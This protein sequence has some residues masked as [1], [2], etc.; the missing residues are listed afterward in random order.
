MEDMGSFL[1]VDEAC[2]AVSGPRSFLK[3]LRTILSA[4]VAL[5]KALVKSPFEKRLVSLRDGAFINT[6]VLNEH[7]TEKPVLVL[8]HGWGSGLGF[9]AKNLDALAGAYRIYCFDWI[10]SGGSSR[11]KFDTSMNV[12]ESED[13]FLR[14]FDEWTKRVGLENEKF[15]LAGHSLGGYLAA[16]YA[17][18]HPERLRGLA[19]ISPFGV[20][21]G[22]ESQKRSTT[23]VSSHPTGAQ[24]PRLTMIATASEA[25][26]N[27]LQSEPANDSH[28]TASADRLPTKYRVLRGV[29]RTFWKLNVT[30][31]R[32]LR[33]TSTAST[34]WSHD[35]ISKYI[36][37][38][39]ASSITSVRE[40]QL[41]A[42]YLYA[43]SVAPGSAEYAI[44]TLMHPGA[45]A[46]APL[47]DRLTALPPT[48]PVVFLY[49]A[50]DWMDPDA[51][52]TLIDK[53]R[54]L[55]NG[56]M[57]LQIVPNAGHY[58]FIDNPQKFNELFL[59]ALSRQI[60]GSA[61]VCADV[62]NTQ[63]SISSSVLNSSKA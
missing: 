63:R 17:L 58:L 9:F 55:G 27:N 50:N 23:T 57:C 22:K 32:I 21:D 42:D 54:E 43:I 8:A 39:F 7:Q 45:W 31:Q 49:G 40:R 51:A 29:L 60:L 3:R 36:S 12:A 47:M 18:Q 14:R 25:T 15:I 4:E 46:R 33:W 62:T 37:R 38:R 16:V 26:P 28:P 13:F 53:A 10:G 24:A 6:L 44:K 52:R 41:L 11:P 20:P 35:L 19:L 61:V 5:L 30:P 59:Q 1:T 34:S 48:V 56:N 2:R